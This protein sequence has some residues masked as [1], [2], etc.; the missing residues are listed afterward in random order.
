MQGRGV[1]GSHA[2][3]CGLKLVS[4]NEIKTHKDVEM[5]E[6]MVMVVLEVRLHFLFFWLLYNTPCINFPKLQV[7][8]CH[9]QP[10]DL[11][12]AISWNCTL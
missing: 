7:S 12:N 8:F 6:A 10:I 4:K 1:V 11:T 5:R 2:F 9:L 3:H